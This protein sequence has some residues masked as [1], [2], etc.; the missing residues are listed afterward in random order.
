[1]TAMSDLEKRFNEGLKTNH[2]IGEND[3][4]KLV[5][6]LIKERDCWLFNAQQLQKSYNKMIEDITK[7]RLEIQTK[8][9]E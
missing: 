9:K 1:M 4:I 7:L 8:L 6:I 2:S 5:K 3:L